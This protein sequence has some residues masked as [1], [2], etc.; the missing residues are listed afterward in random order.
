MEVLVQ[1]LAHD[2]ICCVKLNAVCGRCFVFA[3][4]NQLQ[5]EDK[6]VLLSLLLRKPVVE[7]EEFKA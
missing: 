1:Y 5:V 4:P 6:E 7:V 2:E 3:E